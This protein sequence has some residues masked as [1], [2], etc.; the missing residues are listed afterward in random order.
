MIRKLLSIPFG[1]REIVAIELWE[2]RWESRP[3]KYGAM[4]QMEA[5][6]TENAARA[7]EKAL[8]E[9]FRLTCSYGVSTITVRKRI[10]KSNS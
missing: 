4:P 5:F 2:V 10:D 1:Y 7:F 3:S 8:R 9:A 6:P